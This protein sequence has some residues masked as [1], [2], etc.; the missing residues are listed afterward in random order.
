MECVCLN[1]DCTNNIYVTP[2]EYI[3]DKKNK[4]IKLNKEINV[5][6]RMDHSGI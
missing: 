1:K 4:H 5:M 3:K 6:T 2:K